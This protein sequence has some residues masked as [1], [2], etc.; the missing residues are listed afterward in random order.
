M[1]TVCLLFRVVQ[2]YVSSDRHVVAFAATMGTVLMGSYANPID[3]VPMLAILPKIAQWDTL[4]TLLSV[5]RTGDMGQIQKKTWM[6][7][8][9]RTSRNQAQ[10]LA[11]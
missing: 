8:H 7:S 1:L 6:Y 9:L 11:F 3:F 4:V 5:L 10:F 2:A